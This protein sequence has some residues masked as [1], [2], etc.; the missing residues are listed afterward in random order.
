MLDYD[1]KF[2]GEELGTNLTFDGSS[3]RGF[4]PRSGRAICGLSLDWGL[5]LTGRRRIFLGPGKV[6]GLLPR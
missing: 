5:V 4:H 2:L 1:K 3:I 6:A